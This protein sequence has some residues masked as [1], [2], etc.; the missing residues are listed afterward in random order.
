MRTEVE[1]QILYLSIYNPFQ[2]YSIA[3]SPKRFKA[4]WDFTRTSGS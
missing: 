2:P 4:L 3:P 1:H